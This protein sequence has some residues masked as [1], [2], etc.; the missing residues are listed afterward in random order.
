LRTKVQSLTIDSEQKEDGME[1]ALIKESNGVTSS[2][3]TTNS[4]ECSDETLVAAAKGGSQAAFEQ[5]VEPTAA[6]ALTA[7]K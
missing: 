5:L 6:E 3:A 2:T 7:L 4:V 1:A